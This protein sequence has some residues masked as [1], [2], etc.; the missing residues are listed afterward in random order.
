MRLAIDFTGAD[1]SLRELGEAVQR[2]V[3]V[4]SECPPED[5]S[6]LVAAIEVWRPPTEEMSSD[7]MAVL[8]GTLDAL[9][10]RLQHGTGGE[11]P[12][13]ELA[14]LDVTGLRPN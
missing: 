6:A 2:F 3:L 10:R 12:R 13:A 4:V 7:D 9:R 11:R 5:V 8:V 1:D 14:Q